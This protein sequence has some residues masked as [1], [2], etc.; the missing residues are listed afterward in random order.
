M[1][2]AG[3]AK[4]TRP[5][6]YRTLPRERLFA[7]LDELRGSKAIWITGP[8]GAGKTTLASSSLESRRLPA[9]WY[10]M[11]SGDADPASFFYY[12]A[13]ATHALCGGDQ[14]PLLSPEYLPDLQGF[15]RRFFR[16]LFGRLQKASV[17]VFDNYHAVPPASVLHGIMVEALAEVPDGVSVIV[18]SRTEPP[19]ALTRLRLTRAIECL[20]AGD[21]QVSFE[22]ACRIAALDASVTACCGEI[23]EP[24][25]RTLWETSG[26]WAV[27]FALMLEHRRALGGVQHNPQQKRGVTPASRELL[28]DYFA[29]EIFGAASLEVRHVLLRTAFLPL[30]TVPMAEAI[31][32]DLEAGQR[33]RDLYR[34]RYFIDQ[35][36]EQEATYQYHALFREFLLARAR[37]QLEPAEFVL[38]QRRS[39]RLFGTGH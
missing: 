22:E 15:T 19:P 31:S 38:L 7:R 39:A 14:L 24:E 9:L 33:L 17:L 20:D 35:R 25:I 30:F 4:V 37:E 26:G 29:V 12:L 10:Q 11:D 28:F 1:E 27:G 36:D 8:P 2:Y 23:P 32:G 5:R 6:L 18:T 13:A 21:L 34:L 16:Q 3:M